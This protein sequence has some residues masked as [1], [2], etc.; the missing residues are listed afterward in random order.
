MK[1]LEKEEE[2]DSIIGSGK[3]VVDFYADWCGPCKMLG[4]VLETV[5]KE[6][7][8]ITFLKVNTDDFDEIAMRFGIMSIPCVKVFEDGKEV[9]SNV[10]FMDKNQLEDFIK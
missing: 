7:E 10:G 1:Y 6:H 4:P 3:V 8:D 9:K 2:F 5:S